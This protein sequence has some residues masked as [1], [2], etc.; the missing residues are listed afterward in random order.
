[1]WLKWQW[2]LKELLQVR[3]E[4]TD[5]EHLRNHREIG[6]IQFLPLNLKALDQTRFHDSSRSE[7]RGFQSFLES[8]QVTHFSYNALNS[9]PVTQ[10]GPPE[11]VAMLGKCG[12]RKDWGAW[13]WVLALPVLKSPRVV[14]ASTKQD[15]WHYRKRVGVSAT[16]MEQPQKKPGK[17][18]SQY[19]PSCSTPSWTFL[20]EQC[21][22]FS[23]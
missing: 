8:Y 11:Q 21:W 20:K 19:I 23:Q 2:W 3:A 14:C 5:I 12:W 15:S 22:D 18:N 10:K 17:L 7:I 6:V 4:D 9:I 13:V 1:M 16:G